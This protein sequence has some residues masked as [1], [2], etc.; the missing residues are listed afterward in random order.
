M[1]NKQTRTNE[2]GSVISFIAIGVVLTALVV[3]GIYVVQKRG[4]NAPAIAS[5]TAAPSVSPTPESSPPAVSSPTTTP[6]PSKAA[7]PSKSPLPSTGVPLPKT[8]PSDDL[9][10]ATGFAILLG[11]VI[12][13][14]R[15]YKFRFGSLRG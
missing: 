8:G 5:P 11:V 10:G 13:Y 7:T 4:E 1:N 15:S 12:A 14:L 6:A 2:G 3:G 9:L